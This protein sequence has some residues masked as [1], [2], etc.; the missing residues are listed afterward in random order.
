MQ[1]QDSLLM[2]NKEF[3]WKDTRKVTL[4]MWMKSWMFQRCEKRG[5]LGTRIAEMDVSNFDEESSKLLM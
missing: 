3:E 4:F 2:F 5:A 1:A